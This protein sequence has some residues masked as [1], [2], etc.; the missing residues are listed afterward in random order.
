MTYGVG[1]TVGAITLFGDEGGV[2]YRV[3]VPKGSYYEGSEQR[4]LVSGATRLVGYPRILWHWDFFKP[5]WYDIMRTIFT[6][7][8]GTVFIRSTT[9]DN[10]D[11]FQTFEAVYSWPWELEKDSYRRMDFDIHFRRVIMKRVVVAAAVGVLVS[12]GK[13]LTVVRT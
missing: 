11:E 13:S 2:L 9:N 3:P 6:E 5:E 8:S 1:L 10:L 12:S 4:D 7:H